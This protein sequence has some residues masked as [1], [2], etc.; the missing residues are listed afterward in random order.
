LCEKALKFVSETRAGGGSGVSDEVRV[1]STFSPFF[2]QLAANK[3][4]AASISAALTSD[5][6]SK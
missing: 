5:L 2:M 3:I 4:M 6:V 1:K